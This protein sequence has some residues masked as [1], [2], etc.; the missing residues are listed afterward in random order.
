MALHPDVQRKA[1]AELDAV[2]DGTHLPTFD[3]ENELPYVGAIVKEVFRW[4][5]VVPLGDF[6]A[7]ETF[8][9]CQLILFVAI[10]HRLTEDDVYEGYLIPAGSTVIGNAWAILHDPEFFPNPESFHPE[11]FLK[12]GDSNRFPDVA[13]GFGRRICPGQHMAR[14]SV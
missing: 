13:F 8:D 12:S 3:D 1:H 4:H 2:L 7:H 11:R 5:P 9:I 14:S 10:P 6:P